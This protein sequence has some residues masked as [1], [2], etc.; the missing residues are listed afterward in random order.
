[1]SLVYVPVVGAFTYRD[2]DATPAAGE[3]I[4]FIART[5]AVVDGDTVTLP[6]K[7][8]V[9]L[10]ADG[11]VP[12]GFML[13]TVGDGVYYDVREKFSG[14]RE[15]YTI[16][17]LTSDTEIDLATVSPVV[18]PEELVSIEQSA[19][20]Q[21]ARD[22]RDAAL[23]AEADSEAAK[24]AAE[25]ARD[26]A[27]G[28]A[29]T[30]SGSASA[31]ASSASAASGSA[32]SAG[33]SATT[34]TG[35]KDAAVAAKTAAESARD[36]AQGHATAASTSAT[37]ASTAK[38]AAESAKDAAESARN[39][40]QG[41]AA[42]AS[43]KAGEAA[44]SATTAATKAGEAAASATTAATK[45]GEAAASAVLAEQARL[46]GATIGF[47]TKAD[48]D[49]DL[50]HDAGTLALVTNDGTAAN[51]GTYRKTGASGT[52]S[53]VQSAAGELATTA[54]LAGTSPG[55]GAAMVGFLQSGVGAVPRLVQDK[56]RERVTPEDFGAVGDGVANDTAAI[57]A[58]IAAL[59]AH[60]GTV[61]LN[62][63][64]KY[65]CNIII[66]R[67]NINIV[68]G[69]MGGTT[70]GLPERDCGLVPW[71]VNLPVLQ[72]GDDTK[73][74]TGFVANNI[75]LWS[76]GPN[77]YGNYGLRLHGGAT[78]T[79]FIGFC[80]SGFF[81]KSVWIENGPNFPISYVY[82][83]NYYFGTSTSPT[84]EHV[85][86]L[87]YVSPQYTTAVYLCNG[88]IAAGVAG[89]AVECS[90]AHL[91][92]SNSWWELGDGHGVKLVTTTTGAKLIASNL[93]MDSVSSTDT[94][95]EVSGYSSKVTS[96]WI[97]GSMTCDG[98]IK[99]ADG[100]TESLRDQSA[101]AYQPGMYNPIASG[102]IYL[103]ETLDQTTRDMRITRWGTSMGF[104]S[105]GNLVVAVGPVK[106]G[107][108]AA[109]G[110]SRFRWNDGVFGPVTDN[111]YALGS[112]SQRFSLLYAG[113]GTINTSDAREKQQV[114]T[115]GEAERAVAVR[116][117]G[118]LR[119]FKFRD[120][121]DG[122]GD[123]ARIHFGVIAQDVEAA[124]A[125]EGLD[126]R[127]YALFCHDEWESK[128]AVVE[129]WDE[130]R[131]ANGNVTRAAGGRV[132]EPAVEAGDLYGIRYDEL[133]A[134]MLAAL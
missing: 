96:A 16:Q 127:S 67:N 134:F 107:Y 85:L 26:A 90:G 114:R 37:A 64:K 91:N 133:L 66:T 20:I 111:T 124:F 1:M 72:I 15:H 47:A 84:V 9:T 132:V 4:H 44:A 63:K 69:S 98:K 62:S 60:G 13:P 102:T 45:A 74:V 112:A 129:E 125:A 110:V 51:N 41:N 119:A 50:A 17:V 121:V 2:A 83:T 79:N 14:G 43:T 131:D 100:T 82:F 87:N 92:V 38:D 18:P 130:E 122:K 23:Q 6:K 104:F 35:A 99:W 76:V 31:A 5:Q 34:A 95:V 126:A 3:K 71:D 48:M 61:V 105:P 88:N 113:S 49:A 54:A 30:A 77:G 70:A 27:Q 11:E 28:H 36:A 81:K 73:L 59:P 101:F 52:G 115:L 32:T 94:L 46:L 86:Y 58:A 109:N 78:R 19:I 7:L 29:L 10:N 118:L 123:S 117:K 106:F 42:T 8:I 56:Q 25:D 57:T 120:A 89:Y 55:Q 40:A 80:S 24:L 33:T 75:Y 116:C 21:A 128:E 22:A 103:T 68:G 108:L 53:W 97:T 39:T 65:A 12:A 93:A